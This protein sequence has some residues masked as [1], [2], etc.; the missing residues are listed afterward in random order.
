MSWFSYW[1]ILHSI[2]SGEPL[3]YDSS[4]IFVAV[5]ED[6]SNNDVRGRTR[7][8]CKGLT[9]QRARDPRSFKLP[10][11]PLISRRIYIDIS[12]F[13]STEYIKVIKNTKRYF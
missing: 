5:Q 6:F 7:A 8:D 2:R 10:G 11:A 3:N 12:C 1:S 13:A 4:E 9:V